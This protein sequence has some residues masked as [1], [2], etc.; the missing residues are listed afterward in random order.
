M[1]SRKE[2]CLTL[3]AL[4]DR[5]VPNGAFGGAIGAGVPLFTPFNS[6]IIQPAG[7]VGQ[8]QPAIQS[9]FASFNSPS[10]FLN[11]LQAAQSA[12]M[13][14]VD[15]FFSNFESLLHSIQPTFVVP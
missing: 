11:Q 9:A 15:Q 6:W 8:S 1:K 7:N 2:V 5:M 3:E 10:Y 12:Q 4:E 13:A 14:V